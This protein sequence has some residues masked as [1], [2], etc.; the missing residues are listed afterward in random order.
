MSIALLKK[1][2]VSSTCLL[3]I[4]V[5]SLSCSK[6]TPDTII[7]AP[8]Y[9]G[10]GANEASF[11]FDATIIVPESSGKPT[12]DSIRDSVK[13]AMRF[14]LGS[15]HENGSVYAG[16]TTKINNFEILD[17]GDYRVFY[18][19]TGKGVFKKDL[20]SVKF[21]VPIVP[22]KLW[23]L[24]HG[25][26][27]PVDEETD[28]GNFW[29]SWTPEKGNC[30]LIKDE[31]WVKTEVQLTAM[32]A[33]ADTYPE[34]ERLV[35]GN[36]LA[37][38]MF[39]GASDHANV[40]WNPMDPTSKDQGARS[41][42]KMREFLVTTLGYSAHE[43]TPDEVRMTYSL[44]EKLQLPFAEEL[45]KVTAN[46]NVRIRL[47]FLETGYLND[48][49]DSFHFILKD[50]VKKESVVMYDGHSGIG[51]NLN[52]DRIESSRNFKI[53]FNPNYQLIY[54]GSCLP[55][56]YYTDLFFKRKITDVDPNG[57]KN[58][59]ILAY[60]KESHFGSVE[61]LRLVLAL[62]NYMVRAEKTSYQN[63]I[64]KTPKDFFG[65]IGD[66]DNSTAAPVAPKLKSP[67]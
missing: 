49:S 35:V 16:F 5:A 31:H 48:N 30:P 65:V 17:S 67:K 34:Y 32:P 54:F 23:S 2:V 43:M 25:K 40:K 36:Q 14:V 44:R 29:Y 64:T 41:Y 7:E 18:T 1:F 45:T 38:T 9:F 21:N 42:L 52:L 53:L 60:A 6:K 47:L 11:S 28:E 10:S 39:F 37:V 20:T 4:G 50:A 59:D 15:I 56:A 3:T 58:L 22:N 51:R 33:T 24:S 61:N 55:Y 63:I 66:E 13:Y 46:G 8:S 62:D 27:Q 26:C 57:T 12:E 19:L